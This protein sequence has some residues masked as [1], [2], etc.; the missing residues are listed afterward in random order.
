[1]GLNVP[2]S[3]ALPFAF[4]RRLVYALGCVVTL[5]LVLNLFA[6]AFLPPALS[7]YPHH[8]PDASLFSGTKWIPPVLD[9][10]KP[11]KPLE[12]DA[13]GRCLFLSPYGALSPAERRA[14]EQIKLEEV[15]PG[16]VRVSND[17]GPNGKPLNPILALLREGEEKWN[18]LVES[19]STTL[20]Q[21]VKR[22]ENAWGRPPPKGFDD[23]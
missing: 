22:Y 20:E 23:W 9:S 16:I 10:N 18:K 4:P 17:L 12:W 6:P 3:C 15:S 2:F 5:V 11:D 19:Q 8:E 21:A 13:N 7:T 1:M 14:A